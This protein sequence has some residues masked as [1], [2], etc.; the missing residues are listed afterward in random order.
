[1]ALPD[2]LHEYRIERLK[3]MGCNAY[4]CAH[5]PPAPELLDAC[6]RL[7]MLVMDEVR[8]MDA[9][10]E[11]L[12]EL[13]SLVRRDRNHPSVILWCLGNEEPIQ[14]SDAAGRIVTTMKR[15]ARKLD[16]TRPVTL[17]MNGAWGSPAMQVVDVLGCNYFIQFYDEFHRDHPGKP[18]VAAEN[19]S[20]VCTRGIYAN[21]V[22]RGYVSA[23]D[24]N[25]PE[26]A[27]L[28][29]TSWKAVADRPW[30]SGTFVWTGF[31]YRGEPTPYRWPCINSHFGILDT[32]GFPKDN[33]YYYQ[34]WWS[35]QRRAAPP[36]AL[37]LA[38]PGGRADRRVGS[39]Q[40]RNGRA[41]AERGFAGRA[42]GAA[43][44]PCGVEG[45]LRAG[46]AGGQG[47]HRRPAVASAERKTTGAPAGIVLRPDR[48][49][50]QADG[51]DVAVV[52]VSVCDAEGLVVPTAGNLV[53]FSLSGPG[54]ILGVGNGD[55][56]C[57]EPDKP[58]EGQASR[59]AFNGLC[60]VIVQAGREP[61]EIV[62]AAEAEGLAPARVVIAA[63]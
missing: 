25:H 50:I 48:A 63:G 17:A 5:N 60:Q 29:E 40:L 46:R 33:Y 27:S 43:Q 26:W 3:E 16:P 6:D 23:Y 51:A 42:A 22:E 62:L 52:N 44:R 38:G 45:A 20:T 37:E 7:G 12:L 18:A 19:A 56:S 28:A 35:D 9:T 10:P 47:L 39:Q 53:R 2:R 31:D 58:V 1:M 21:D 8:H 61:G 41:V 15:L 13:E 36:A 30:M 55:P 57:H 59:S 24:A 4:R 49:V 11:G 32:C 14:G 54:R 34:A